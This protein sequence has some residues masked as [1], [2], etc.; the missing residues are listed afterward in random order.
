MTCISSTCFTACFAQEKAGKYIFDYKKE[1]SL[2]DK[3]EKN[4]R[5][6]LAKLQ[7]CLAGKKKEIGG[8]KAE[9]DM[10]VEKKAD[11]NKIKM[12]LQEIAQVQM[13]ASYQDIVS[14]RA[15]ED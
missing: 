11:L 10:L 5:D 9:L 2:T 13:D 12:K 4:M 6:I 8:L 1:L 7:G 15:I 3:Q 14:S